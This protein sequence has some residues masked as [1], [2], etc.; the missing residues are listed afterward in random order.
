MKFAKNAAFC[1]GFIA[2]LAT[3]A[4][5]AQLQGNAPRFYADSLQA[6]ERFVR[7]Q[8][9]FDRIPGLTVGF[10]NGNFTWVKGF[11]FADLENSVPAKPESSYRLA[12]ITKTITA[13][14]IMELA[15]EGK[16][17]LDAEIQ[18]YVPYFPRKKWPVTVR[19][20]LGHIGGVSHYKDYAV[21]G[22]IKEPKTTR[23]AI[24]IF[25][26]FDL[27]AEPGT[28]YVYSSYGYNLLGAAIE[29]ASQRPYGEFIQKNIFDPLNMNDS[30]LDNPID[31]VPNRVR[32]Y[33][34]VKGQLKNS[35]FVDISSRFAGGGLR[36]TVY[37]LLKYARGIIGRRLLKEVTWRKMFSSMALRNGLMT[38]YGMGWGV[39]PWA[40][41]FA[42]SHSGSQPETRTHLLIFPTE[43]FAVA[44]ACNL[45]GA[46]L[47]PY[48]RKLIG[49]VLDEDVDVK[50]YAPDRARQS[51]CQAVFQA[52]C[53]GMSTYDWTGAALSKS[54]E[55]LKDAFDYFNESVNEDALRRDYMDAKKK[56]QAGIHP[57][58]NQAFTKVGSYMAQALAEEEG[59]EG[60]SRYHRGGPF[61]FF[62]DYIRLSTSDSAPKRHPRFRPQFTG[63]LAEWA[64][65][66]EKTYTLDIRQIDITPSTDFDQVIPKLRASFAGASLYPDFTTDLAAA[67]LYFLGGNDIEKAVSILKEGQKLYPASPLLAA[68]LGF[69][70]LW[71][72]DMDTARQFYDQARS[73]DP[74]HPVLRADSFITSISLLGRA[75]RLTEAQALA[76]IA[77]EFNSKEPNLYIALSDL[78][79]QA[80]QKGKAIDYLKSALNIDPNNGE[81]KAK[82]K[83]LEK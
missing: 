54:R 68:S 63:L 73:L 11:G 57:G 22:H 41:H 33:Q 21:E 78:C 23:E 42:V 20:L 40:G 53:F 82:L 3:A 10:I 8:M 19:Q 48:V 38:W 69:V 60:L 65:D 1:L 28:R 76:L 44:I 72:G 2:I 66:W 31:L 77:V 24:A 70:Y 64:K 7:E 79:L 17:D 39:Q 47:L 36:A 50:A 16:I 37:D 49:L 81:A 29:G 18:A 27:V 74:T 46:S 25:Q 62:D 55:D 61:A 15:E 34:I 45:E 13:L 32:G 58:A 5:P 14:A 30:Q 75:E 35:E 6:F 52:Y 71:R 43:N 56:I 59:Q 83:S 26:D 51:I 4:N 80:G 67:A 12:S 9:T